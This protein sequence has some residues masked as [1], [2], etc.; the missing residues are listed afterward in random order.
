M[1]N[2]ENIITVQNL[3]YRYD[4]T[5][6]VKGLSF[7][8]KK[9]EMFGLVGPDGAGKST[10]IKSL[11]GVIPYQQGEVEILGWQMPQH[12]KLIKNHIGYLSQRFSLYGDLSIDENIQFFAEIH[13][14]KDYLSMREQL[15]EFTRLKPF[16]KRLAEKLSGGMKQKLAL[17]CTLIYR[18]QLILLDEPTTGVDP[19][20]R[21]DFWRILSQLLAQGI[22]F[23]LSTPYMDEAE[24]CSRIAMMHQGEILLQGAPSE[25]KKHLRCQVAEVTAPQVRTLLPIVKSLKNTIETQMFGDRINLLTDDF[26]A[27]ESDLNEFAR[28]RNFT[29][30][31]IRQISPSI[32]NVF[33]SLMRSAKT[34]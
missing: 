19:L 2:N 20:S 6:A 27:L 16:R 5:L 29:I 15:L 26:A 32:E 4:S 1:S 23:I 10:V 3:F 31:H 28:S 17:A 25:I 7:T 33:I 21:R 30:T 11:C 8:V 24:R 12:K 9:G 13:G 34:P 14:V 22:T 18:P